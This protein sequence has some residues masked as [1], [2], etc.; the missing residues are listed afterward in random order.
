VLHGTVSRAASRPTP[1]LHPSLE[2]S[3]LSRP[4]HIH[5]IPRFKLFHREL[6]SNLNTGGVGTAEFTQ[7][8]G[9]FGIRFFKMPPHGTI[10]ISLPL[11]VPQLNRLIAVLLGVF[12]L[13]DNAGSPFDHRHRDRFPFIGENLSHSYFFT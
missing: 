10:E 3:P 1:T 12:N 13:Y 6:F 4:C 5:K 2:S 9:R 8:P 11:I 7:K